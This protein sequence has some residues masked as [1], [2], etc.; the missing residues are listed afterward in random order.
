MKMKLISSRLIVSALAMGV[1][2]SCQAAGPIEPPP[3]RELQRRIDTA[4]SRSDHEALAAHYFK[5]ADAARLKVAEHRK[6]A[7]S[8]ESLLASGKG[9][10]N[11]VEHCN[12]IARSYELISAGYDGMGEGHQQLANDAKH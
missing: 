4:H 8:Y 2:F 12:S 5:Q 7:K 11:M 9:G 1:A 6:L 3:S 10:A